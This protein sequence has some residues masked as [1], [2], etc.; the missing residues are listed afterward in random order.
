MYGS[1]RIEVFDVE[2]VRSTEIVYLVDWR[3]LEH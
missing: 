2:N 1:L 3:A